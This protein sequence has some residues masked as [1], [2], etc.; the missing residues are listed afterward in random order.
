MEL[1]KKLNFIKI[2]EIQRKYKKKRIS[3][4]KVIKKY[5]KNHRKKINEFT[6]HFIYGVLLLILTI[7]F[8]SFF[9]N[10]LITYLTLDKIF[11]SVL[12]GAFLLPLYSILNG[13]TKKLLQYINLVILWCLTL[14]IARLSIEGILLSIYVLIILD[15]LK[16][17]DK[18]S[19]LSLYDSLYESRKNQCDYLV[20]VLSTKRVHKKNLI[21]IDGE[22][23]IG[24]SFFINSVFENE[25]IYNGY[26][27][28]LDVLIFN[29]KNHLIEYTL[30]EIKKILEE[31]GIRT[32]SVGQLKR[33]L[34]FIGQSNRKNFTNLFDD[35]S[36][37]KIEKDLCKD[38]EKLNKP[39]YLIVENLERALD[40]EKIINVLGFI[41]KIYELVKNNFKIIVLADSEKIKR[42][43]EIYIENNSNK[44]EKLKDSVQ[45][46][47]HFLR[48]SNDLGDDYLDKFFDIKMR[49]VKIEK[50]EILE[51]LKNYIKNKSTSN[52]IKEIPYHCFEDAIDSFKIIYKKIFDSEKFDG[53]TDNFLR[54]TIMDIDEKLENP[55]SFERVID[56]TYTL[57]NVLSNPYSFGDIYTQDVYFKQVIL[58]SILKK[59]FP[60]FN[61]TFLMEDDISNMIKFYKTEDKHVITNLTE[62][63]RTFILLYVIYTDEI[64]L[65]YPSIHQNKIVSFYYKLLKNVESKDVHNTTEFIN[66]IKS[67]TD[68]EIQNNYE[69][70]EMLEKFIYYNIYLDKEN[71]SDNIYTHILNIIS[72]IENI[73]DNELWTVLNNSDFLQFD[74]TYAKKHHRSIFDVLIKISD[75][76]ERL[77]NNLIKIYFDDLYIYYKLYINEIK[78]IIYISDQ[79]FITRFKKEYNEKHSVNLIHITDVIKKISV[80]FEIDSDLRHNF[81]E[82]SSKLGKL[83]FKN[84]IF[85]TQGKELNNMK[86][87]NNEYIELKNKNTY[88]DIIKTIELSKRISGMVENI[89]Y[90]LYK[91]INT[92]NKSQ[93]LNLEEINTELLTFLKVIHEDFYISIIISLG[94]FYQLNK[95]L[96]LNVEVMDTLLDNKIHT[97]LNSIELP[98]KECFD[99]RGKIEEIQKEKEENDLKLRRDYSQVVNLTTEFS[100]GVIEHLEKKYKSNLLVN[101]TP[102]SNQEILELLEL[103]ENDDFSNEININSIVESQHLDNEENRPIF[104][105]VILLRKEII[106][107]GI[108]LD[109]YYKLQFIREQKIEKYISKLI[110]EINLISDNLWE[111]IY[112]SL[113]SY[114]QDKNHKLLSFLTKYKKENEVK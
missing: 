85:F 30:S 27:I 95:K 69:L 78:N 47:K 105:E 93:D 31:E 64:D 82:L 61:K 43:N 1:N 45:L 65:S 110:E 34:K 37:H 35:E 87:K 70:K 92:Y 21:L 71:G 33:A 109:L 74:K 12:F 80:D 19:F 108:K 76:E 98:V 39:V 63:N 56:D 40:K 20:K 51:K 13:N 8:P 26:R 97:F 17:N 5:K 18:K 96:I 84:E 75:P 88:K 94:N 81:D 11:Y 6:S 52:S 16:V 91:K 9:Q 28:D 99:S 100:R 103:L 107:I 4:L 36:L 58:I 112:S 111:L 104:R 73:S 66:I 83:Y 42:I 24:K 67:K 86:L 68:K 3:F 48:G 89:L 77:M 54:K 62:Y 90:K 114:S 60:N 22:W 29:D 44:E 53:T 32:N 57:S 7:L 55:R 25:N 38:I 79:E 2:R 59:F 72:K 50:K 101:Q 10:Y 113:F 23:G 106:K 49:L 41:H 46:D 15:T 14:A 102:L